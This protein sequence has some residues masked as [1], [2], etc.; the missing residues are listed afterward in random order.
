MSSPEPRHANRRV[1]RIVVRSDVVADENMVHHPVEPVHQIEQ[2]HRPG[3]LPDGPDNIA[4]NQFVV[5]FSHGKGTS[6]A[7]V[8]DC[9][10][11][12]FMEALL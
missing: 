1:R 6:T 10:S 12:E 9:G 2:G 11:G 3:Q 7:I 4:G 5:E 8:G